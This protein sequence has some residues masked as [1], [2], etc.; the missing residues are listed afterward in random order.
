VNE[1]PSPLAQ[2]A[3][4]AARQGRLLLRALRH[5]PAAVSIRARR[6]REQELVELFVGVNRW[7][8]EL[9]VDYALHYGTLLGWFREGRI[10]AHDR[11]VDFAAPVAAY[12]RIRAAAA[13]LPRGFRLRDT[14]HWHFGP[15][16]CITRRGWEADIY[17]LTEENGWLR[18]TER[19]RNPGDL[20]PFPRDWFYPLQ[21]AELHGETV[22]VPAQPQPIL[23]T[24]YRYLGPDAVRDPVTRYFRPRAGG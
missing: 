12:P 14:S 24:L 10:L 17:F 21:T 5:A 15:K 20:A 19:S 22:R 8:R 13:A 23:E 2:A 3:A 1:I 16:L 18:S 6:R 9:G 11:D 7:L 4:R